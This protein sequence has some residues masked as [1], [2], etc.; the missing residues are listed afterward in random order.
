MPSKTPKKPVKITKPT[1][2]STAKATVKPT[3]KAAPNKKQ[4]SDV[5]QSKKRTWLRWC[6]VTSFKIFLVV[7]V[8]LAVYVIYLDSKVKKTFEGQRWQLPVQVY[9]KI[10]TLMV[11]SPLNLNHLKTSLLLTGY[12]KVAQVT[13][14]GEF[15]MSSKRVIIQRRAF[16][17]GGGLIQSVNI[18]VDIDSNTINQIIVDNQRLPEVKLEPVLIDRIVPESKEDRVIV[19]LEQVPESLLDALLLVEDR[20]FYHHAGVS[21]LGILRALVANIQ[22]GRT[23]QGGSTLTQQLVKNMFLTR[24][25]TLTRKLNEALMALILEYHYSKDQLLEAY[26][27]EVYLGQ[28]YANG[29][30]GFGL[31][32][33][34]YFGKKIGDLSRSQVA[35]LIGQIKGPSYY[36]PWRFPERAIKRRDLILQLLF[37]HDFLTKNEYTTAVNSPLSVRKNRRIVKQKQPAYLQLV[38]REL[39]EILSDQEQQSGVKVFTGFDVRIQQQLNDTVTQK[40]PELE[41]Q[42]KQKNIE[43]AM[44]VTDHHS[45]EVNALVGGRDHNYAGFNRSLNANRPIGSLVKPAIYLAALERNNQYHLGTTLAD[46]PLTIKNDNG[47]AW[48]PKNY[49]GKFHD[50]S[51]LYDALVKSLNVPTVNLGLAIGLPSVSDVLKTLGYQQ[52]LSLQPSMLLGSINMSPYEINQLYLPLATQGYWRESHAINYITANNGKLIWQFEPVTAQLLSSQTSYLINYALHGVTTQGTAKSLTW[53]LPEKQLAGK[54]GTSNDLRD[55][56]F[57]GF[58]NQHLVT[59]WLGKD[60]NEKTSFT[61]SSGALVLFSDAMKGIGVDDLAL[62][63]ASG[64]EEVWFDNDSGAAYQERC[65]NSTPYPANLRA[66]KQQEK[67]T[68]KHKK[69]ESWLDRWFGS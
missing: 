21:P 34:F 5:N 30:Y 42:Y 17:F 27:N 65:A 35:T 62:T 41:K 55:S 68:V 13:Q 11:G 60:N 10:E 51:N 15:A 36:D 56:W 25:K 59:T 33:E 14:P 49:D 52:P 6:L 39:R 8:T 29:I 26:I 31:A 67:C 20:N 48:R 44:L 24:Q 64:I 47:V 9:G 1:I 63:P 23:V 28:H 19:G 50:H 16:D 69:D 38:K 53:R 58:D 37:E 7:A 54:T 3:T 32:A 4:P 46:K 45:G 57:I 43:V 2:K 18:T 66:L 61:G 22:A 12:K 40:L